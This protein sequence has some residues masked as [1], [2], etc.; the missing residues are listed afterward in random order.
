MPNIQ[1]GINLPID[2]Y[3]WVE[4]RAELLHQKKG[5]VIRAILEEKM[6]QEPIP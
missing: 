1:L 3:K 6:K 4:A 2:M 5:R